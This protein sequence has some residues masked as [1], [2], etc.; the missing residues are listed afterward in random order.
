MNKNI[1]IGSSLIVVFLSLGVLTGY[2]I[3]QNN[4]AEYETLLSEFQEL[5]GKYVSLLDDYNT[6]LGNYSELKSNC[7]I[8]SGEYES[9]N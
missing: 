1:V 9:L 8:I 4:Q 7:E 3:P 2:F 6:L 5:N